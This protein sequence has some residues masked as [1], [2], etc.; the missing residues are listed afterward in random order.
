MNIPRLQKMCC[1]CKR[2]IPLTPN[3]WAGGSNAD[4][5]VPNGRCCDDCNKNIVIPARLIRMTSRSPD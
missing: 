5:V 1:I 4:P 3:G 2:Q